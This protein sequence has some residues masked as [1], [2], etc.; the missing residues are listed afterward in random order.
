[1]Y[2]L[3]VQQG[4]EKT[5]SYLF[6][7]DG[8]LIARG[9]LEQHSH[10]P[11]PGWLEQS[12]VAMWARAHK[13]IRIVREEGLVRQG[14]IAGIGLVVQSGMLAWSRH[15]D[16]PLYPAL[17]GTDPRDAAW[18]LRHVPAVQTA[19]ARGDLLL[20]A[21]DTWLAW[22]L[23]GVLAATPA[24]A[25][26]L[27][28]LDASG[29]NWDADRLVAVGMTTDALPTLTP[30]VHTQ[31]WGRT[32][33]EGPLHTET[34]LLVVLGVTPGATAWADILACRDALTPTAD[35]SEAIGS[36]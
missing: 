3:V 27:G 31:A 34:P 26:R 4:L 10:S 5:G 9:E 14:E 12:P 25:A 35:Q 18:L 1:M 2:W 11:Q 21:L 32:C 13:S 24:N 16:R 15:S 33:L 29:Q 8:R 22:N 28:L 7:R 30:A 19:A 6:R 20:G 17:V 23:T 36:G